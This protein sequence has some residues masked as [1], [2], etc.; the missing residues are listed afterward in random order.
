MAG[1]YG[2]RSNS[3]P[4][5]GRDE[6]ANLIAHAAIVRQRG[7]FAG[8][9]FRQPGRIIEPAM[10]NSRPAGKHRA[11]L[12]GVIA[13]GDDVVEGN[14]GQFIDVP[15]SLAADV[16]ARL[17]HDPDGEGIQAVGLDA[18]GMRLDGVAPQLPGEP[19]RHLAAAG[20]ARAEGQHGQF[21]R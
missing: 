1:V 5:R 10:H 14:V 17:G 19:F 20:V 9:I 6:R 3:D 16:H 15:G 7:F 2:L 11:A 12:G 8:R 13:D 21:R 4:G 18:G